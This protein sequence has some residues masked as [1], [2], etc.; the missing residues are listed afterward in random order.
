MRLGAH[1]SIAKGLPSALDLALKHQC[2]CLQVFVGNPRSWKTA[3]L[4][5]E[6]VEAFRRRRAQLAL[7]TS[8]RIEP[9]VAHMPYLPNLASCRR[10]VYRL[11][12]QA[13][14]D[15]LDRCARLGLE[16]LVVHMGKHEGR[17]IP[18]ALERMARAIGKVLRAYSGG[19]MLLLE[20]TAGQG[21][22]TGRTMEEIGQL[23]RRL[24]DPRVGVCLDTCH[25]FAAGYD[26]TE[27]TGLKQL[28]DEIETS[29]GCTRV[30]VLHVNDSK[31]PCGSRV[32]RHAHIGEGCIGEAGFRRVLVH[33][34]FRRLPAILE[35][36]QD[37]PGDVDRNLAR[38]RACL[39]RPRQRAIEP[40]GRAE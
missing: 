19:T 35:T 5:D 34:V 18:Q 3:P 28:V 22:E 4:P 30:H 27:A 9:V 12:R 17:S 25:L 6:A 7:K 26:L 2:Q 8:T 13:L 37:D 31:K 32:D 21:T 10:D 20:N 1:L 11:S 38:L 33:P 23:L 14:A 16:Y 39:R 15:Q 24:D 36:P 29:F 40:A